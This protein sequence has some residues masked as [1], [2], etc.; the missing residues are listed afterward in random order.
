LQTNNRDTFSA[1]PKCAVIQ[2]DIY[3]FVVVAKAGRW[4]KKDNEY[5]SMFYEL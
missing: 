1:E 4:N 3:A 2:A 5:G